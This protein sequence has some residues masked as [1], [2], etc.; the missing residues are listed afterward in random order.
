MPLLSFNINYP[1]SVTELLAPED[2]EPKRQAWVEVLVS[3]LKYIH[4]L[5]MAYRPIANRE[6]TYTGQVCVLERMLNLHYLSVDAWASPPDPTAGGNIY[7]EN[8]STVLANYPVWY[9]SEGQLQVRVTRFASEG[10]TSTYPIY[11]NSEYA[12]GYA[13]IVWVPVAL[14]YDESEMR[15]RLDRYVLAGFNYSIQTY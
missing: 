5:F 3:G 6:A 13:F 11:F 15:A 10:G 12:A 8:V 2:R 7:I 4:T 1:Q 9:Q 14:A